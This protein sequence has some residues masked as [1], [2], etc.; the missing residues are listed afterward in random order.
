MNT[1]KHLN[2]ANRC[3]PTQIHKST[4]ADTAYKYTTHTGARQY[5]SD[6]SVFDFPST[7][8]WQN[9]FNRIA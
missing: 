1:T 4:Y 8:E 7:I 2:V 6:T 5:F 3:T 9:S